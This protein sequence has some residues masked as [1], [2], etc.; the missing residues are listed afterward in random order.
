MKEDENRLEIEHHP[1]MNGNLRVLVEIL[2][3]IKLPRIYHL[4]EVNDKLLDNFRHAVLGILGC[5]VSTI[6]F[7][8]C[9]KPWIACRTVIIVSLIISIILRHKPAF[10]I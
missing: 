5:I 1:E 2:Y 9:I 6:V 10:V 8:L 4:T 7:V 3:L